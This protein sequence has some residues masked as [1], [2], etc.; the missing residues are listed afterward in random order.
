VEKEP[1]VE[2]PYD[3]MDREELYG[4]LRDLQIAQREINKHT[5]MVDA[6]LRRR[7]IEELGRGVS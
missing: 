4:V 3:G 5:G 7:Y 2:N 6:V 1:I